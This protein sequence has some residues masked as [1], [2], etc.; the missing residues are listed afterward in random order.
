MQ[1]SRGLCLAKNPNQSGFQSDKAELQ[2][3]PLQTVKRNGKK[4]GADF[5]EFPDF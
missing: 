1:D 3:D 2:G 4:S 5:P